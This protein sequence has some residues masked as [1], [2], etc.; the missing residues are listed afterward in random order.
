M[1][2]WDMEKE[3]Q[4]DQIGM[5]LLKRVQSFE[6]MTNLSKDLITIMTSLWSILETTCNVQELRWWYR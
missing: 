5:A 4:A 1:G 6:E 2:F 3:I